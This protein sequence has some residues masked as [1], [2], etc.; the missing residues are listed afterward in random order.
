MFQIALQ[1]AHFCL[2]A[3]SHDLGAAKLRTIRESRKGKNDHI[4]KGYQDDCRSTRGAVVCNR[5]FFLILKKMEQKCGAVGHHPVSRLLQ[6][7]PQLASSVEALSRCKVAATVKC[8]SSLFPPE[9]SVVR[10]VE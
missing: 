2:L 1:V 4:D 9:F 7:F 10:K 3:V 8:H 6:K 5:F